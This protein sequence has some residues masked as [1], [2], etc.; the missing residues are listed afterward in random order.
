MVALAHAAA[1]RAVRAFAQ[2]MPAMLAAPSPAGRK[3]RLVYDARKK[4]RLP[5]KLVRS[6]G[7]AKSSDPASPRLKR[8]VSCSR[9]TSFTRSSAATRSTMPEWR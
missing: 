6:E 9:S 7:E 2:K 4:D 5:G 3:Y 8:P 1:V